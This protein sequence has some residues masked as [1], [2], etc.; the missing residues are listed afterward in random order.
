ML[1][2]LMA[3]STTTTKRIAGWLL[4]IG[5]LLAVLALA[6]PTWEREPQRVFQTTSARVI[7][8][9]LSRSMDA[10]DLPPSRLLRARYKIEDALAQSTEGQ[11]DLVVYAGD[12]FTVSP[13]TRDANTIR[14]LLKA[15][16]PGIMPTQGSRADLGLLK[17]AELLH[18]AGSSA[19]QVLLMTDGVAPD[20]AAATERA[21]AQLH[22]QGYRVSILGIGSEAGAVPSVAR[23]GVTRGDADAGAPVVLDAATLRAIAQAGGGDYQQISANGGALKKLLSDPRL[24]H[25]DDAATGDMKAQSWKQRGPFLALLLLPLAALGFRRNWLLSGL[26]LTGLTLASAPQ[27]AVAST[28]SDLWQR[29]D[30]QAAGALVAGDYAAA[31]KVAKDPDRLGTAEY[32]LGNYQKAA[33]D[34]ARA[35]G[36]DANYNLGNALAKL[37]KYQEAIAAYEKS[38][39]QK[40][41]NE[42]AVVNKAAVE[43]LL[44]RQQQQQAS[45]SPQNEAQKKQS[46]GQGSPQD[47]SQG[48]PKN[49]GQGAPQ[50]Q[51]EGPKQNQ[52][53]GSSDARQGSG[54]DNDK[55]SGSQNNG[56]S[57]SPKGGDRQSGK[58]SQPSSRQADKAGDEPSASATGSAPQNKSDTHFAD[59]AKRLAA[60]TAD[61]AQGRDDSLQ[62]SQAG[63]STA[64]F[65]RADAG[66][67]RH[68]AGAAGATTDQAPSSEEQM[69]AEQWLRRIPDDPGGLLR[70]KFLYQ[71]RQRAQQANSDDRSP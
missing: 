35:K 36:V 37:G 4:A 50:N 68:G 19:G 12:A 27:P 51:G 66:H 55:N 5:W 70:R 57:G 31:S 7:V 49:Q 65:P 44:K 69:A 59:A 47:Q 56:Q 16:D 48:S 29:P 61:A 41:D 10:V 6:N 58:D 28:W 33:D 11:T 15:V 60:K 54:Q 3:T 8:L 17:A 42:D 14:A 25:A 18:Q 64:Q 40:P 39:K 21:A 2:L 20:N 32:K 9:S 38:L 63:A 22:S 34:F 62:A 26:L 43:A 30:Q 71:Y 1:P 53:Q 45:A 24:L 52:A 13:L 23:T 46:L 67:D